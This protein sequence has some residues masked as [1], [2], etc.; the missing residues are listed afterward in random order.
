MTQEA[1]RLSAQVLAAVA[2]EMSLSESLNFWLSALEVTTYL[3]SGRWSY[4]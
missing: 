4:R 3:Y 1:T 2:A